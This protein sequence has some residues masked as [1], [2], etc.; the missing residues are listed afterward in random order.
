MKKTIAQVGGTLLFGSFFA[1]AGTIAENQKRWF[2]KYQKQANAPDPDKML[3]NEDKEPE[4]KEGFVDL[5]NGKDLSDWTAKGGKASVE[6]KDGLI[7]G[8]AVPKTP[9]TYLCT[10]KV[11]FEDF[12]FTCEIKWAEDLNSGV[13]FRASSRM[14]GDHEEVFGPQVEMEGLGKDRG[15]SGGVYG[16]SYGGYFYPLWL[17]K[18]ETARGA[19]KKEGWN[20]LIVEAKGKVVKTWVNGVPAA[21]WIGDGTYAKGFFGLQIH[22]AKKGEVHFR[23]LRVKELK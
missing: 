9:S 21:H 17:K 6:V 7:V 16:Q 4:L 23:N 12:V 3:L 2:K 1:S 19:L 10:D 8:K 18:H 15:W 5:F 11:D 13:M 22:K 20:R 14:K